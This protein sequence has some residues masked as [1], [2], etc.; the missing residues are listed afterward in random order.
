MA[1]LP[2]IQSMVSNG[3]K[4]S[5]FQTETSSSSLARR[6]SV[7]I[8]VFSP[9][10]RQ[11]S[12]TCSHPLLQV[13]KRA[14]TTVHSSASQTRP[15]I[16]LISC[17][18]FCLPLACFKCSSTHQRAI[19]YRE[20]HFA[21]FSDAMATHGF[22]STRSPRSFASRTSITSKTFSVKRSTP[23]KAPSKLTSRDG[24]ITLGSPSC[25]WT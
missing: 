8:V 3:A 15:R 21:A 6:H 20:Y 23:Y 18:Y 13:R 9:C 16:S 10:S 25:R 4:S 22:R 5:G 17:A 12:L 19:A 24:K 2:R 11:S 1:R 14:T 7:F